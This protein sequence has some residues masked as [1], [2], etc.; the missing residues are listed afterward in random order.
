MKKIL[1]A[2]AMLAA[3]AT[4]SA[5]VVGSAHDLSGGYGASNSNTTQVCIFCH[6]PHWTN[7]AIT[8]APLW[9]RT[10]TGSTYTVYTSNTLSGAIAA[11]GAN[12]LTCLA[13][14]DGSA[15]LGQVYDGGA[16]TN[17]FDVAASIA[18][19]ANVG[20]D[21]RND[22]PVGI[23]Y[24]VAG[25]SEF[26]ANAGGLPLYGV[27]NTV[28]CASCHDPHDETNIPFLRVTNAASALCTTCHIK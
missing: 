18:G 9:N 28:E 17:L 4:A 23:G 6:A 20:T 7:T 10:S 8:A 3:A 1:V 25:N 22:H 15:N 12:S 16:N 26:N 5:Q 11:V 2:L 24:V 21:L 27:T 14:H 19:S 13:C